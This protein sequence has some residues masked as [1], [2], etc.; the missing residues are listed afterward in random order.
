MARRSRD[1][2]REAKLCLAF[3]PLSL[4]VLQFSLVKT[5]QLNSFFF[6]F[7]TKMLKTCTCPSVKFVFSLTIA[8]EG[9][10]LRGN[11]RNTIAFADSQTENKPV[12]EGLIN[13]VV[14]FTVIG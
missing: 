2:T 8:Y 10:D 13:G 1:N 11:L 3:F 5:V 7:F 14:A 9:P 4:A 6:F 12:K